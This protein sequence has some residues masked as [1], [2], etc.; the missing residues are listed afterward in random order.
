MLVEAAF[1]ARDRIDDAAIDFGPDR[2]VGRHA[3]VRKSVLV[4]R[5]TSSKR[6]L[7]DHQHRSGIMVSRGEFAEPRYEGGVAALL[8]EV[9]YEV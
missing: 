7:A 4:Q 9:G 6:R 3:D 1:R 5:K 2:V 8:S